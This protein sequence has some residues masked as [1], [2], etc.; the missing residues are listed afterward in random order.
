MHYCDI[1]Y[2]VCMGTRLGFIVLRLGCIGLR[3][4]LSNTG[5]QLRDCGPELNHMRL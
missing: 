1:H 5:L 3:L 2:R 4:E